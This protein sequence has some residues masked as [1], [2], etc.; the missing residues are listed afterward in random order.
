MDFLQRED[1]DARPGVYSALLLDCPG[2]CSLVPAGWEFLGHHVVLFPV[3]LAVS[4]LL[5]QTGHTGAGKPVADVHPRVQ[6]ESGSHYTAAPGQDT[7]APETRRVS[8]GP[9]PPPAWPAWG[10]LWGGTP[11]KNTCDC[12]KKAASSWSPFLFTFVSIG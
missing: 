11:W 7:P 12:L 8:A 2:L 1:G 6:P 3:F 9:A 10:R 5:E 4:E